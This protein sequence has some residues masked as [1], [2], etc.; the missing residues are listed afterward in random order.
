MGLSTGSLQRSGLAN[1]TL[2]QFVTDNALCV[3]QTPVILG[4]NLYYCG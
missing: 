4:V 2:L 1:A 3:H